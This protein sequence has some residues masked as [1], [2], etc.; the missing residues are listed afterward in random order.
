MRRTRK[1]EQAKER[2]DFCA[3]DGRSLHGSRYPVAHFLV[4][5]EAPGLVP[6]GIAPAVQFI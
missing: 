4:S 5:A 1:E 3:K 2:Q 6:Q